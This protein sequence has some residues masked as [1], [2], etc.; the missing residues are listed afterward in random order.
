VFSKGDEEIERMLVFRDRLRENPADRDFYQRTK[1]E[2]AQR[3]WKFVQNYA[4]A[5][6]KVVESI[7]ARA[8]SSRH[9]VRD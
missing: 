7:I 4:D 8:G 3:D 6:S 2:L 1:K 9:F 5:K